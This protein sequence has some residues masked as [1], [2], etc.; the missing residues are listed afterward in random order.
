MSNEDE[1][2]EL[3]LLRDIVP[4]P[5]ALRDDLAEGIWTAIPAPVTP[6]PP[7]PPASAFGSHLATLIVGIVLGA[8]GMFAFV[9]SSQPATSEA[10]TESA[11]PVE[12]QTRESA[13][14]EVVEAPAEVEELD[15]QPPPRVRD[16]R[17]R[18]DTRATHDETTEAEAPIAEAPDMPAPPPESSLTRER[19]LV[20]AARTALM[21]RNAASALSTLTR[22]QQEFGDGAQLSAEADALR[23]R[24]FVVLGR[25][26]EACLGARDFA[27][28]HPSD[29]LV[30]QVRRVVEGRCSD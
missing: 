27:E 20:D 21:R 9:D 17:R 19:R 28:E 15:G 5:P 11:S 25:D 16:R 14:E 2:S 22:H 8:G 24:A 7:P 18:S 3:D 30:A 1:Q 6:N 26:D 10:A 12:G 13:P 23:I 29:S 4:V